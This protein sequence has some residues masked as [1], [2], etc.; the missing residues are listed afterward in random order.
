[1]IGSAGHAVATSGH[2]AVLL[3]SVM[4]SR[5]S[6]DHLV[7]GRL[8]DQRNRLAELLGGRQTPGEQL[9]KCPLCL[10]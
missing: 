6:L 2:A 5:R 8:H 1:M 3:T 10:R 4:N 7:G 9:R